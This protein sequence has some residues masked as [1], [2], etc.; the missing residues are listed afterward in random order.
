[1]Q[2]CREAYRKC[3]VGACL[4]S[5]QPIQIEG[6]T[7]IN[8]SRAD[9]GLPSR[10]PLSHGQESP[11]ARNHLLLSDSSVLRSADEALG[12]MISSSWRFRRT[13]SWAISVV[14]TSRTADE[15]ISIVS[16]ELTGRGLGRPASELRDIL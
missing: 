2:N 12:S 5:W 15:Q 16:D 6:P 9:R 1:M 13:D 10:P 11:N 14:P 8:G 4:I 7:R 3:A